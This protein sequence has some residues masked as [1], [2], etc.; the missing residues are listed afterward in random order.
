MNQRWNDL[1]FAH[2]PVP[3]SSISP[4]L[5]DDLEVDTF[6]GSAWL[7]VVPFWLDRVKLRGAPPL[8]GM[9]GFP[10]LQMRTYVREAH[11]GA[12]GVFSFWLD[13]GS[14][15]AV[16]AARML[17][18]LPYHWSEMRLEQRSE[19]EFAFFSRRRFTPRPVIFK[20]RYRG[21]GPTRKL[22]EN[23]PGTLEYFLMERNCL[24][25][26]NRAGQVIRAS[27]HHASWPLEEAQAEIEQNDLPESIGIHLPDQEPVLHYTRR[28]ALY[29]WPAELVRPSLLPRP[30][31]VAVSPSG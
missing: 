7:G 14:L 27:L 11:S 10:D 28:L 1:L 31:T 17:F 9:G 21:L 15:L 6:Q 18:H 30:V 26:N 22:A 3:A 25:A 23:R 5:P 29:I 12:A 4:L 16:A 13:A 2:W 8:P 24:F 19:R 20:A